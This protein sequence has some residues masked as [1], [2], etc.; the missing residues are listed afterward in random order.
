MGDGGD[1]SKLG[2][3][4]SEANSTCEVF[5][6]GRVKRFVPVLLYGRCH[7]SL[8]VIKYR[9]QGCWEVFSLTNL[10]NLLLHLTNLLYLSQA[11]IQ[12]LT[13]ASK[14]SGILLLEI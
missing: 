12:V 14:S 2:Y 8:A 10:I 11:K 7:R 5:W 3:V 13:V 1:F 4:L 9:Y 6:G